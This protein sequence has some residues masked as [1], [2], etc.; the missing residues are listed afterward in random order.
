MRLED[1]I[2]YVSFCLFILSTVIAF[3]QQSTVKGNVH[4]ESGE[5][6]SHATITVKGTDISSMSDKNGYYSLPNVPY[7]HREIQVTAVEINPKTI[8]LKIDKPVHDFSI[9]VSS[10]GDIAIEEIGRASC[11]ERGNQ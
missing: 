8:R 2:C 10:K 4:L 7:G 3:G 9:T 6:V 5:S 11:R 1:I